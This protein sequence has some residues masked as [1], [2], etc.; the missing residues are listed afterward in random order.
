MATKELCMRD[1]VTCGS[2]F[3]HSGTGPKRKIC[4]EC[5]PKSVD[6]KVCGAK[7]YNAPSRDGGAKTCSVECMSEMYRRAGRAKVNYTG[8]SRDCSRCRQHKMM[9][10]FGPAKNGIGG[11]HSICNECR[12]PGYEARIAARWS[13]WLLEHVEGLRKCITCLEEKTLDAFNNR[14]A[15]TQCVHCQ[16]EVNLTR[17]RVLQ[18]VRLNRESVFRKANGRCQLRCSPNCTPK[19]P[20]R[21]WHL[22]HIVPLSKGG[23]HS[24]ENVQATCKACNLFKNNS[25][26]FLTPAQAMIPLFKAEAY[27]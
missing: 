26:E 20:T 7:V 18:K 8:R 2:T 12:R 27:A 13:A 19:L 14:H 15:G 22:D 6:C 16:L 5:W 25:L 24:Y 17:T 3:R 1:C 10:M 4:Y 23:E 11:H 21:G 9:Y